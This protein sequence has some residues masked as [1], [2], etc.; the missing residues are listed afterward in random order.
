VL[1]LFHTRILLV[2]GFVFYDRSA[3]FLT[4]VLYTIS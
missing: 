3:L 2:F 4:L 1:K